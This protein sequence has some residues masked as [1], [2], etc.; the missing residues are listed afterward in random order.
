MWLECNYFT[1]TAF[2][3]EIPNT[4]HWTE[5]SAIGSRQYI[6]L[7]IKRHPREPLESWFQQDAPCGNRLKFTFLSNLPLLHLVNTITTTHQQQSV[8]ILNFLTSLKW[9]NITTPSPTPTASSFCSCCMLQIASCTI[10][11]R[12]HP[13]LDMLNGN[14]NA[15]FREH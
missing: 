11:L 4:F 15:S 2:W 9:F 7:L 6:T 8:Y 10:W 1:I 3:R 14:V 5:E 12:M 13:K